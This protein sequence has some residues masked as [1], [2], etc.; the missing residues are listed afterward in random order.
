MAAMESMTSSPAYAHALFKSIDIQTLS[1]VRRLTA[2]VLE[3]ERAKRDGETLRPASTALKQQ[4]YGLPAATLFQ[5]IQRHRLETVLQADSAVSELLPDLQVDLQRV[6]R[7]EMMAALALASL[8]REMAALFE[9]AGISLLVIKGVPLALQT[10]GSPTARGRGDCD[11]FVDPSQVGAAIDLL[12]SAGF[13]LSFG[14]SCVGDDSFRGRYSRFVT[15][16]ISL[17][18]LAG[19]R[20]QR[21]DLHW[22][23]THVRGVM[24][25]F[26]VLWERS[27]ELQINDQSVRTL[28]RRDAL[29]HSCCHASADRWMALRNLV[30]IERL[31][32]EFPSDNQVELKRLR[33]VGNSWIAIAD[34]CGKRDES[35]LQGRA[36][37][38]RMKALVAQLRPWRSMGEGEWTEANRLR[39]F[40]HYLNLS[41]HPVH[42]LSILLQQLIR[43]VDL[44]DSR[45]GQG[46]SLW[47]VVA[48]RTGKLRRR[49]RASTESLDQRA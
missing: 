47:Q 5:G 28:S 8:T 30:D 33:P 25:D 39:Y 9:E 42:V 11:L 49:L 36:Q 20:L 38:V 7:R 48:L 3:R 13:A 19:G 31:G 27:E 18:R 17:D 16:E 46:R 40:A 44:I 34:V 15:I 29:V 1:A 26:E 43:P 12:Q 2:W 23:P 10:T 35:R 32:R 21:I 22:H 14:A 41:R 45:T 6:A 4:L 24:S 37:S